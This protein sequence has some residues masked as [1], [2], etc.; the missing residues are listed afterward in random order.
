MPGRYHYS[1]L[2]IFFIFHCS[3]PPLPSL[4]PSPPPPSPP[5]PPPPSLLPLFPP[6]SPFKRLH[7]EENYVGRRCELHYIRDKEGREGDYSNNEQTHQDKR[8]CGRTPREIL[9]VGKR[10][11]KVKR[12]A[13]FKS[14]RHLRKNKNGI[15][16]IKSELLQI[17]SKLVA[18]S[19]P[20][21]GMIRVPVACTA[22]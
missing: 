22:I 10:L 4:P 20:R 7:F 9:E 14:D 13:E 5:P 3:Y 12:R 17:K 6:T 2:T 16:Q 18:E 11:R 19:L 15:C 8:F 21:S 1:P